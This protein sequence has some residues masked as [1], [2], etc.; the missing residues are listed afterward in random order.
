MKATRIVAIIA[1]TVM[2]ASCNP[3]APN[4][5][6]DAVDAQMKA[7]EEKI[8][9][10][11]AQLSVIKDKEA[12]DERLGQ[13]VINAMYLSGAQKK[14]S[15]TKKLILAQDIVSVANDIFD[16]ESHKRAFVSIIAIESRFDRYAQSPTGPRGLAQVAKA[17]FNEAIKEHCGMGD[18]HDE[19]VWET[20]INLY[21]GACYYRKMLELAKGDTDVAN[22]MY[23]QGPNSESVK[24]YIKYGSMEALEPMKYVIKF[25]HLQK[26]NNDVPV[27]GAPT[28]SELTKSAAAASTNKVE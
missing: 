12:A 13:W 15:D 19:D 8:R 24:T 1:A 17:A 11:E 2:F 26:K 22:V 16:N 5:K 7:N 23:N 14:L 21:A 4:S 3:L 9:Q 25:G 28:I 20:K 18:I 27:Q 10:L 6:V